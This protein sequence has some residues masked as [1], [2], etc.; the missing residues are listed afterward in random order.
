MNLN[1]CRLKVSLRRIALGGLIWAAASAGACDDNSSSNGATIGSGG[2]FASEGQNECAGGSTGFAGSGGTAGMTGV[3]GGG[4]TNL[5]TASG[6]ASGGT[7]GVTGTGASYG[8]TGA[9][10]SPGS[11][12]HGTPNC[13]TDAGTS[14]GTGTGAGAST[15]AGTGAPR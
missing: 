8:V 14:T 10:A 3:R 5:A 6:G 9:G 13:V 4:G 11:S 2:A 1:G 15:G 7:T 12:V